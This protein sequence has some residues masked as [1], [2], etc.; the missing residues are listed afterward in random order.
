MNLWHIDHHKSVVSIKVVKTQFLVEN[1][2]DGWINVKFW[3]VIYVKY[4]Q[5]LFF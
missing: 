1:G 4:G 5:I 2:W 3:S